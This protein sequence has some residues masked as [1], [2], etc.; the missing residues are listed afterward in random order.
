MLERFKQ[1]IHDCFD[2]LEISL[3]AGKRCNRLINL[4]VHYQLLIEKC[5][6]RL[7]VLNQRVIQA[8][9]LYHLILYKLCLRERPYIHL[10]ASN[11]LRSLDQERLNHHVRLL[12]LPL[13]LI[14]D[15]GSVS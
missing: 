3:Q 8:S 1:V 9:G 15:H 13:Q 10:L 7:Q 2:A 5:L 11:V 14:C 4:V 6:A 12:G